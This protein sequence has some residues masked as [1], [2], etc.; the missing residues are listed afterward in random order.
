MADGGNQGDVNWNAILK[1]SLEQHGDGTAPPR[2]ISE[3]DRQWFF[4]AMESGVI[5]EIKRMKQIT[6]EISQNPDGQLSD[7]DIAIREELL[8]DLAMRVESIDNAGDLHTIGGFQP[9]IKTLGSPHPTLRALA[10]EVLATCVQNHPKAQAHALEN[11]VMPGLLKM[12]GED[13]NDNAARTK[14]LYAL[15]C[16]LRGCAKAIEAFQ[17]G[18]GLALLAKCMC[19]EHVKVRTKALHLARHLVM[20]SQG[21]MSAGVDAGYVSNATRALGV[22]DTQAREAALRLLVDM[23]KCCD[24]EKA[25][26]AVEEFRAGALQQALGAMKARHAKLTGEDKETLQ[27]ET[28]LAAELSKMF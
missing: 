18:G 3:E 14:A 11:N 9:L 8:D 7:E 20:L 10:A 28:Q 25:P 16:L 12:A 19:A 4:K 26:K 6:E 24:F 1:W 5:D 2:E 15:S 22:E 27:D 21:Y 23:A 13:E 17:L